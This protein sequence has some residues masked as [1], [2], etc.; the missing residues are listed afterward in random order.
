M[1]IMLTQDWQDKHSEELASTFP[2]IQIQKALTREKQREIIKESEVVLGFPGNMEI[3]L[4]AKAPGLKWIQALSAGVDKITRSDYLAELKKNDVIIT[5][6]SGLHKEVIAEHTMAFILAFVKRFLDFF[7]HQ[8]KRVWKRKDVDSLINKKI[9]IVG[10]GAIGREIAQKAKTFDMEVIGV[11]KDI[12]ENISGVDRLYPADELKEAFEDA[13][14][15]VSILPLTAETEEIFGP[16]EFAAMPARSIFINVG[17]GEL[18]QEEVLIE[19]LKEGGIAGAALD[20]FAE[21]PLDALS[22][23]YDMDNVI[24]TPHVAGSFLNYYSKANE[25]VKENISR[26]LNNEALLNRVNYEKGY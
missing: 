10:L 20:V 26:Y 22:P 6:V 25:I 18:V 9:V 3:D 2:D 13:D 7:N 5:N 14:F 12:T 21:E 19:T 17:R 23:L 16:E 15:I 11:K 24:I 8:K 4:L 1:K